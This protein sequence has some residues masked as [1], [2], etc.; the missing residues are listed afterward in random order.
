M[1]TTLFAYGF[2]P[3]FLLVGFAGLCLMP[4]WILVYLGH[5]PL[6]G[7]LPPSL[8]HGHEMLYGLVGAA[9]AG[10]LLTAVPSWTGHKG[11]AGWPLVVMS[12]LWVGARVLLASPDRSAVL[13]GAALD[14]A[15]L[16]F[17]AALIAP[18]LL[19]E[20]NRNTPLLAV[21]AVLWL[22]NLAFYQAIAAGN[23]P[24]ASRTLLLTV[25]A[26]LV[27]VTVIGGRIVPA[28]TRTALRPHG[29]A[30]VVRSAP[31]LSVLAIAAMVLVAVS[32]LAAP[33][34][35]VAGGIAAI[36]G[37]VQALRLLQWGTARTLRQPIVWVLHAAYAWLPVGLALKAA[38]LLAGMQAAQYWLHALTVG[39]FSTMIMAVMT[40][41]AL[42][43]TGRPIVA[44]RLTTVSYG[45]L[46]LAAIARVFGATIFG[47]QFDLAIMLAAIFWTAAFALFLV[48]YLPILSGPRADG[49]PG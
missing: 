33:D 26:V 39:A 49:R 8:W 29:H 24:G 30:D 32:D 41:A 18:P 25:D 4:L 35:A 36:A 11:F 44:H 10:F 47:L 22:C 15:F 12:M 6:S 27:L 46:L 7:P 37:G 14:L 40:R 21:I 45:L 5:L 13:A 16:P 43:H 20:K 9:I 48:I 19:R 34:T 38:A 28:F 23:M 3:N 17:L 1:R 42:G 31:M 2:R